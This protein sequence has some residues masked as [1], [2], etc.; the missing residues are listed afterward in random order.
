[1]EEKG[2]D[3]FKK[4]DCG[5][6]VGKLLG[7]KMVDFNFFPQHLNVIIEDCRYSPRVF[8]RHFFALFSDKKRQSFHESFFVLSRCRKCRYRSVENIFHLAFEFE[9][10]IKNV[11]SNLSHLL[12]LEFVRKL[13]KFL[14]ENE[15]FIDATSTGQPESFFQDLADLSRCCLDSTSFQACYQKLF[16][17]LENNMKSIKSQTEFYTILESI[18]LSTEK[19]L[20]NAHNYSSNITT[21]S[22]RHADDTRRTSTNKQAANVAKWV[23]I[24]CGVLYQGFVIFSSAG[25]AAAKGATTGSVGVQLVQLA[26]L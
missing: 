14:R 21:E 23:L 20:N 2:G 18:E 8:D 4:D 12:C 24:G 26:E 11:E 6:I 1:V 5:H 13:R 17:E 25:A 15:K 22:L 3:L 9:S 7:G 10:T 16:C 19:E